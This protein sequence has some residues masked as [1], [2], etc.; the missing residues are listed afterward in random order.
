MLKVKSPSTKLKVLN[1]RTSKE[2]IC[3]GLEVVTT[4]PPDV[5]QRFDFTAKV[6]VEESGM[7]EEKNL[8]D[9]KK[10]E[11][12]KSCHAN[13]DPGELVDA[14]A[15]VEVSVVKE[16]K[17]TDDLKM[18]EESRHASWDP[19]ELVNAE[20]QMF[21]VKVEVMPSGDVN[22]KAF[23]GTMSLFNFVRLH[24]SMVLVLDALNAARFVDVKPVSSRCF[25][26]SFP[27]ILSDYG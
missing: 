19:G 25:A 11:G 22:A 20:A 24:I 23:S 10:V 16:V 9:D 3:K 13:W 1:I 6:Q 27:P 2:C 7:K 14:K 21:N 17:Q 12:K 8:K 18:R 4:K 5:L 26:E 15:K